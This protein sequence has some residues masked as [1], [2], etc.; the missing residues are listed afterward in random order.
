[1]KTGGISNQKF[2][3]I[4]LAGH[5]GKTKIGAGLACGALWTVA[6]GIAKG[7]VVT[8]PME[9]ALTLVGE[10]SGD[11]FYVDG[12]P[13]PHRRPV[14]WLTQTIQRAEMSEALRNST[15][16]I[17]T[18]STIT[19]YASEIE[20]LIGVKVVP[21]NLPAD[22]TVDDPVAFAME[23][24]EDFLVKNWAQTD[25][26]GTTTSLPKTASWWAS[27]TP[28]TPAPWMCWPSKRTRVNC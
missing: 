6:K 13:F 5:P 9:L 10:V 15:G 23:T 11:Y 1:L 22:P 8:C 14:R 16:S 18:V 19:K 28:R 20:N 24:L 21:V 4:F 12:E 17:G 26:A 27:N 2:I 7:D 25:W 3:P